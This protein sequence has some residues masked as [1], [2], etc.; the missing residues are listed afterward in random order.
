M[1]TNT[2]EGRQT[3]VA[4]GVIIDNEPD[5]DGLPASVRTPHRKP[6]LWKHVFL[7]TVCRGFSQKFAFDVRLSLLLLVFLCVLAC[8]VYF[9]MMNCL[10]A[11]R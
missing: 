5:T 2:E 3:P 4:H 11:E 9:D 1:N 8:R 6:E 10:C 7:D